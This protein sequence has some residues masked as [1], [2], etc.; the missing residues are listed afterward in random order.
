MVLYYWKYPTTQVPA[1]GSYTSTLDI[2]A[3]QS[4]SF[5]YPAVSATTFDWNSM[6]DNY[7][8]YSSGTSV[9]AVATLMRYVGQAERMMYGTAAAGG[10]GIYTSNANIIATMFKNMGYEST[11]RRVYKSTYNYNASGWTDLLIAEMEASRP[12]VYMAV[13]DDGEGGHAFNV[14][15]YRES[16]G[17]FHVNFGW[18]G[19]GNSW[20][21]MDAFTDYYGTT[22]NIDQQ[23]IIGVQPPGGIGNSPYMNVDP[24]SVT[25]SGEVGGTYTETFIVTGGN[26]QSNATIG[27]AGSSA[28]TISPTTLTPAQVAAGATVTVTYAPGSAGNHSATLTVSTANVTSK[29][30]SVSGTATGGTTPNTPTMNVNPSSLDFDTEVGTPVQQIFKVTGSDL[31][32]KVYLSVT[33]TGYS[34]DKTSL[35]KIAVMNNPNG[36]DVTVTYNPAEAGSHSGL[37]TLTTT[38]GEDKAVIL[39]GTATV[40]AREINV[41]PELLEFNTTT[42]EM[43]TKTFTVVGTNLTGNLSL[44]LNNANGAYTI[45][46]TSITKAQAEAGATVTVKYNPSAA[47]THESTVT[48]SG[49]D[50]DSKMVTL[51]GT[52]TDPVRTITVEPSSLTF[53]NLVGETATKTFTVTGENLTGGINLA[54]D[55]AAGVYSVTPTSLTKAQAEAGATV[56]VTYNPNTFGAH[57]AT[58]TLTSG[59]A[60]PVTVSLNGLAS[61]I[62]YDPVMLPANEEHIDLTK[63]RADWTDETP[64]TNVSSYTLEVT[65]M[66]RAQETGD[67][68]SRLITGITD[69]FYTVNDLAEAGTFMY[70]VKSLYIDGT[71]SEWSNIEEVTLLQN[72]SCLRGDAD[73]SGVVDISDVTTLI[74]F[75][76][77]GSAASY[78][79]EN[80]DTDFSGSI[81]ISDVTTLISFLLNGAW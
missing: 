28:F 7:Y 41:S 53:N 15:G 35:T 72:T 55:D 50:A 70:R 69:M 33:G 19:S 63:F 3:N 9:T 52:A 60:E 25:F 48:I 47:G 29:L 17:K 4:V 32:D 10:S 13:G 59:G 81:D 49:G 21:A 73:G 57:P 12:I 5:T 27:K 62:K 20:Y 24:T 8:S 42:G 26:L 23:A 14:D 54:L 78:V 38:G 56:S 11:A 66:L 30:V 71:E 18:S 16:D 36:V 75:L 31:T 61:L 77:N 79:E 68:N 58:I 22:Y 80:A 65:P 39:N 46:P 34:I 2:S 43:Q 51:I 64:E 67:Q 37:V 45:T 44:A 76:L 40:P 1:I 6:R 74:G